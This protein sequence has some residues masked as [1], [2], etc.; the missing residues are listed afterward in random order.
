M[1]IMRFAYRNRKLALFAAFCLFT[2]LFMLVKFTELNPACFLPTN[3]PSA[4]MLRDEVSSSSTQLRATEEKLTP[5][6]PVFLRFV[7]T[8]ARRGKRPERLPVPPANAVNFHRRRSA[9]R[10]HANEG[11]ARRAPGRAVRPRDASDTENTAAA[12]PLAQVGEGEP[13]TGRSGNNQRSA[14][15]PQTVHFSSS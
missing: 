2:V 9:L 1:T 4:I 3:K 5:F 10:H 14:T 11:D 15:R 12:L 6:P 8:E 13:A 7:C